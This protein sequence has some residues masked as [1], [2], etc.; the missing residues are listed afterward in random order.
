MLHW[1]MQVALYLVVSSLNGV[2]NKKRGK[3]PFVGTNAADSL[4]KFI[5]WFRGFVK[6]KAGGDSC[7]VKDL[8]GT[9]QPGLYHHIMGTEM[10]QIEGELTGMDNWHMQCSAGIV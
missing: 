9:I 5:E 6:G 4:R 8:S 10:D 2:S 7:I 1:V 3:N